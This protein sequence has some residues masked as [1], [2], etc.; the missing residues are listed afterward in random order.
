MAKFAPTRDQQRAIEARGSALLVSAAAGSGKTKVLTERLMSY[1]TQEDPK[2]IDSFLVITFTRAAAGELRSRIMDELSNLMAQEPDNSFLRRQYALVSRAQISTIHG[3]CSALIRENCL[4]LELPP[5]FKIVEEART[6]AMKHTALEKTLEHCYERLSEDA[7]LGNLIDTVGAGRD[8]GR[9]AALILNL[10]EKM[11]SHPYPALWAESQRKALYAD[12]ITDPGDTV[13][14][15]YLLDQAAETA[16]YW[17]ETMEGLLGL[18]AQ[19]DYADIGKKCAASIGETADALRKF[20]GAA[21]LGWDK[22]VEHRSIPFPRMVMPR[23]PQHPEAAEQVKAQRE[24]CKKAMQKLSGEFNQPGKTVLDEMRRTAPAMDALLGLTLEFDR[25]YAAEKRRRGFVDYSDLEHFAARLLSDPQGN[26]TDLARQLSQRYTEIMVDEYQDVNEVQDLIFRCISKDGSNLFTVGDVKQSIY[27]FRL[28]D[29][30]IFTEKYL[31]YQDY[32]HALPGQPRRILLQENFRS[33]SQVLEA[34]NGVFENI[35]SPQLGELEYDDN[36]RLRCGAGYPG[37]VPVPQIYLIAPAQEH[38]EDIAITKQQVEADFVAQAIQELID[39]GT[40]VTQDGQQRPARYGDIALLMRSANTVG[41]V[42]RKVLNNHGIPVQSEQGGG[43]YSSPEISVM[44]ALLAV[45]D[46]PMQDVPLITVLQSVYV[47]F[48]P[49]QLARVRAC[50]KK[51]CFYEALCQSREQ[52][53]EAGAFLD[54]LEVWRTISGDIPLRELIWKILDDL[55]VFAVTSA[56][57]DG[58]MRRRNLMAFVDLASQFEA[59]G[60]QGL[61]RF[62]VWLERQKEQGIEPEVP[63]RQGESGVQIMSIHRSKG[64]EFPIV[65][66]CDTARRFNQSDSMDTVLVHPQMGLGPKVVDLERGIEYHSMPRRALIQKLNRETLSEEMRL[67]YVAMTRAKEYLFMTG[68]LNDPVK[69]VEKLRPLVTAPV[70]PQVLESASAPVNWLIAAALAD[71][72]RH[73]HLQTICWSVGAEQTALQE[74]PED[75]VEHDEELVEQLQTNL[76]Y[77]YPYAQSVDLPSKVTATELKYLRDS[78]EEAVELVE[79]SYGR[80]RKFQEQGDSRRLSAVEK[81]IAMHLVFQHIDYQKA[82]DRESVQREIG[83][84]ESRGILNARQARGVDLEQVTRFFLSPAGELMRT[85]D[86]VLREFKFSLL[87]PAETYFTQGQGDEVLLQG[88]IDCAVE[89]NGS[90]TIID[91]KTDRVTEEDVQQRAAIYASQVQAYT[92]ALEEITGQKVEKTI[93]Y[94]L[95]PGISVEI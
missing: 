68:A 94:F 2:S 15:R 69:T 67:L 73:L 19:P 32:E 65:F 64:L 59:A 77:R 23:N 44:M 56:M 22:A 10:Y 50:D 34:A 29:P 62:V 26:P 24:A 33:R 43:F 21:K 55:S 70:S 91:Y 71:E 38:E 4:P 9:L 45:V 76:D 3:F 57:T 12:G 81:G 52:V 35:M 93:L 40:F 86:R 36:A 16:S 54:R 25:V 95:N 78:D 58:Q 27:R 30:G 53:A 92:R 75:G 46:N 49:D 39:G 20:V 72:E 60:Y 90:Y 66:L 63:C 87:C 13:W 17:A 37:T 88:V 28:A 80:F 82:V 85:G 7:G 5:D 74:K 1:L 41:P 11:Q 14:G 31:R 84:L 89:K 8:D 61:R 48:T 51:A 83:R 79:R 6:A 47:G 18:M 42:Y